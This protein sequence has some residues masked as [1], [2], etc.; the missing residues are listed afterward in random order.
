MGYDLHI[1]RRRHW[2]AGGADI[3]ASEWL[4]VVDADPELQIM[5]DASP[6]LAVW[7]GSSKAET[8]WLNWADG[9]ISAKNPPPKLI[10][11]MVAIAKGL[12]AMVQGDDGEVY[13]S[14]D[15]PPRPYRPSLAERLGAFLQRLRPTP[16]VV[17]A[18]PLPPFGVGD[19]VTDTSGNIA[20]ITA[21]DPRAMH[22]FGS[23]TARYD[24]GR[25]LTFAMFAHN[26][27]PL[28]DKGEKR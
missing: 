7:T 16:A 8:L 13:E 3:A 2:T 24:D 19:R 14:G 26:L 21:I 1:T 12:G 23:I 5:R 22:G 18:I 15:Q 28:D 17:P 6:Y 10:D 9:V 27:R 4:S 20:V 11:K 25:E